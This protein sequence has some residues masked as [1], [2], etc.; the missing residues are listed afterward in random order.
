MIRYFV[1]HPVA[2]NILMLVFVVLGIAVLS[3]LERET[4][5]E[6]TADSVVITVPY[7]GASAVDVDE[8]IC[9][10]LEDAVSGIT[11]LVDLQCDSLDGRASATAEL[12]EGGNL[13]QFFND[14]FSAVSGIN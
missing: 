6:F 4:F 2:A 5:P 11:G 14:V 7:P 10:P 12:D 8:E 3:D 1:R 13:I 9:I